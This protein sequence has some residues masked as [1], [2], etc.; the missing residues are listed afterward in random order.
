MRM[1][2]SMPP[3]QRLGT[4]LL[5]VVALAA[6]G[7]G[8]GGGSESASFEEPADDTTTSESSPEEESPP[9]GG[10]GD[11]PGGAPVGRAPGG[12]VG[13]PI[14]MPAIELNGRP[15]SAVQEFVEPQVEEECGGSLCVTLFYV[16]QNRREI[17]E[18]EPRFTAE[19][20]GDPEI[21]GFSPERSGTT[22]EQQVDREEVVTLVFV[23][24]KSDV[25]PGGD[26]DD[27]DGDTDGDIDGDTDEEG[28]EATS[29]DVTTEALRSHGRPVGTPGR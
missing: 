3:S 11:L 16:D 4:E 14:R 25:Q 28:T 9:G 15:P 13:S 7:C 5:L 17:Q 8:S 12:V 23:C 1:T 10:E 27:G 6:G 20:F 21:C 29:G 24:T 2:R 19:R 26:G 22:V 18:S